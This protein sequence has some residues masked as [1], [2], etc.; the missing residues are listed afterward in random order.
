M[1]T[2]FLAFTQ[3]EYSLSAKRIGLEIVASVG[4]NPLESITSY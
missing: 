3:K 1:P 2:A 4:D